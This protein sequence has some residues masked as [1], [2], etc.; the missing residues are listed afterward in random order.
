MSTWY[1]RGKGGGEAP[2]RPPA[3]RAAAAGPEFAIVCRAA[4]PSARACRRRCA[5]NL[6][7]RLLARSI[8]GGENQLK[9]RHCAQLTECET[10]AEFSLH[11]AQ[12]LQA[13]V[14]QA[15]ARNSTK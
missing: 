15:R 4:A 7:T 8:S 6:R 14:V 10:L 12:Q 13:A 1:E 2:A 5:Q 11:G 3:R 9:V